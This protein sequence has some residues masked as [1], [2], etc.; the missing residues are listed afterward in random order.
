MSKNSASAVRKYESDWS[1]FY[2]S[3]WQSGLSDSVVVFQ[4]RRAHYAQANCSKDWF[5]VCFRA[6]GLRTEQTSILVNA[7]SSSE[8]RRK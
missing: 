8:D 1:Q 2:P 4:R 5:N 7:P 3:K 6:H